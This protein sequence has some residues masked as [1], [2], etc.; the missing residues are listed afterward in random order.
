MYDI[1]ESSSLQIV[2]LFSISPASEEVLSGGQLLAIIRL[3]THV[4]NGDRLEPL[5]DSVVTP[6]M[7][8]NSWIVI[9]V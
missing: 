7:F 4:K 6:G 9:C 8:L 3:L 1:V 5:E 2:K